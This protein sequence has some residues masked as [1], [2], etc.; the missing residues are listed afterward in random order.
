V[1]ETKTI[2][3]SIKWSDKRNSVKQAFENWAKEN[4]AVEM[5][6]AKG[7]RELVKNDSGKLRLINIWASWSG[8]SVRQLEELV[9]VNRMYRRREFELITISVD[10]PGSRNKVLSLLKKQQASFRNYLFDSDDEYELMAAL[11]EDMLGGVPYTILVRPGGEVI[12]RGLGIVDPL[13]LKKAVV[14]YLGRYYK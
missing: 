2:G 9:T 1:E 8:P 10:S 11:D 14:E 3:C 7:V 6:D 5:I 12:Y 13:D 4:V